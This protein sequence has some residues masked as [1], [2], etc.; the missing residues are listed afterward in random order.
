M[1]ATDWKEVIPDDE[2]ARFDGY[3]ALIARNQKAA[4]ADG[5]MSRGLHAK[6]NVG[7]E[8]E[9]E[10]LADVPADARVGM[11]AVPRRYKA[12]ARFSNGAP[13]R[14]S[15]R[16]PDVRG[17]AVKVFG[18]DGKKVIPGMEDA[19]TQDFLAIRTSVLPIRTA[20]EF[21]SIIRAARPEALLPLRLAFALGPGRAV[22]IIRAALKGMKAP[23]SPLAATSFYSAL[24]IRYGTFAAQYA[25]VAT[26]PPAP[27]KLAT[28]TQLGDELAATL[29]ERAVTYDMKIRFY[30]DPIATPIED[31][32][33]E[34]NTPWLTVARL[35]LLKQDPASA[36]GKRVGELVE[37]LS[38]DPWHA[39]EDL[40]P[41]GN[42]MRAR[43]V[44]YR[45]STTARTAAPEPR[46]APTFD[47]PD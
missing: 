37:K 5:A 44:A 25:F 4:A 1:P 6:A 26:D 46:D 15:D 39:R 43:N 45:A 22:S 32:S 38:F 18:V 41:L 36:R 47:N 23:Q 35:T 17:L 9:L 34:W 27:T 42:I 16:K 21:M 10:V 19:T 7:V 3:A 28:P 20:H 12:L 24:P 8:A 40:R 13:R 33:V 11:F 14:Q 29:R 2:A 30:A 31:A